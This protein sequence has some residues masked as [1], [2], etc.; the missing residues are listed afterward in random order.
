[1]AID[2]AYDRWAASYDHDVNRT[3]DLDAEVTRRLHASRRVAVAVE[4]GCGTGK[5]T[6]FFA[7]RATLLHALDFSPAML[8]A[9]RAK[10]TAAH[11][12]F[13][14]QDLA[15]PWALPDATADLVSFNLVLEH[16]ADLRSVFR[17]AARVARAG[18]LLAVSELHPARQYRGGQ[19]H[20]TAADG[21][22]VR[23]PAFVHHVSEFL[24]AA[25]AAGLRLERL[26]EWWHEADAGAPPRLLTLQF[27]RQ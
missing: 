20:F 8:A 1:M 19:A 13:A 7:E 12:R 2:R 18:A 22:E 21:E 17:E 6:G 25:E 14:E 9:A 16:L 5:N 23:V 15:A 4:A 26:E 24:D 10:H 3:R 11:I 27:R